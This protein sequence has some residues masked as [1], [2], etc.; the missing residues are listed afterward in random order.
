MHTESNIFC[1]LHSSTLSTFRTNLEQRNYTPLEEYPEVK[2][3]LP[4]EQ[5]LAY[6]ES[7]NF[8]KDLTLSKKESVC[9]QSC[10][11]LAKVIFV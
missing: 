6:L 10:F 7:V 4:R 1:V 11:F 2:E 5:I 9:Q 3:L 8:P